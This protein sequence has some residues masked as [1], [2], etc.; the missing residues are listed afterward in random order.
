MLLRT[1]IFHTL[2]FFNT[3]YMS[4]STG[5]T[6]YEYYIR[7]DLDQIM[8]PKGYEYRAKLSREHSLFSQ[9]FVEKVPG[10]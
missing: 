7:L 2:Y 3:V 6:R 5:E 9:Q 8:H 10:S 1:S 4:S